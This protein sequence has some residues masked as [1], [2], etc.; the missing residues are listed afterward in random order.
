[1]RIIPFLLFY[2][3]WMGELL[4][5]TLLRLSPRSLGM[6]GREKGVKPSTAGEERV[7]HVVPRGELKY[8]SILGAYKPAPRGRLPQ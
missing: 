8:F 7:A 6:R 3:F 2:I 5:P 4:T 1:L